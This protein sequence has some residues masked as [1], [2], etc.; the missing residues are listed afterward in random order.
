MCGSSEDEGSSGAVAGSAKALFVQSVCGPM[1]GACQECHQKAR[2]GA[3]V[4]LGT[5]CDASYAAIEGFPGLISAPTE[6]LLTQKGPHSGP[7]FTADQQTLVTDWLKAEVTSRGLSSGNSRPAN[8]RAA[9]KSFGDCMDY[10]RYKALKLDTLYNVNT[11]NNGGACISCHNSGQGGCYLSANSAD[12]FNKLREFPYV[13]KLVVG[14][15]TPDNAF[16]G[17]EYSYRLASKGNEA[18][19][20]LANNHPRFSLSAELMSN[21]QIYVGETLSNMNAGRCEGVTLP[22]EDAGTPPPAGH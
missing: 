13:Q 17:L 19:Q 22:P 15:V 11:D 18:Q 21:L 12:T 2:R 14:L 7:A 20:T 8:L 16:G 4:F 1:A 9:F 6:S 10:T 3:P 5:S